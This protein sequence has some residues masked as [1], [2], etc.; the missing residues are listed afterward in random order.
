MEAG[1]SQQGYTWRHI[2]PV[3]SLTSTVERGADAK[4]HANVE[5]RYVIVVRAGDGSDVAQVEGSFLVV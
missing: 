1:G 5:V 3:R 4:L 2:Q